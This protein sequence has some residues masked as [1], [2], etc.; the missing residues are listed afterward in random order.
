MIQI[1]GIYYDGVSSLQTPVVI[2]FADSSEVRIQG[3]QIDR[4]ILFTQLTVDSRLAHTRR[5]I[6]LPDGAKLETEENDAID[7]V[8]RQFQAK[9]HNG[10]MH[11]LESHW[12]AALIALSVCVAFIWSGI[13][14]GVPAVARWVATLTPA[15]IEQKL[16]AQTLDMLD[17]WLLKP[18][19][20]SD[21]TTDKLQRRFQGLSAK[22]SAR[23]DYRLEFRQS[24]RVGANAVA[25][26]G[27]TIVVTDALVELAESEEQMVAVLAHEI[28]HIEYQ[29]G[30]RLLLQNSLAALFMAGVLGDVTSI[31]SLSSALPTM[32]L[33]SRYSRAFELEAD[34]FASRFLTRQKIPV[35]ALQRI[36][37]LLTSH[38]GMHNENEFDYFS[39][40]PALAKRLK[41]IQAEQVTQ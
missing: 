16:G 19:T 2:S 30:L 22:L 39:S 41:T 5:N 15:E 33:E 9:P 13:E 36:L 4:V 23:H 17:E 10:L 14:F 1:R 26:P 29:H 18:T 28:G 35:T 11:K 34:R 7:R 21:D 8:C 12:A 20:L 25:L 32:L 31:T 40:H 3:G 24:R 27:G 6:Y 37:K 38:H